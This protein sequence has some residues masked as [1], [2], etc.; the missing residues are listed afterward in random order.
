[1][2]AHW[3][4]SPR[5]HGPPSD[6]PVRPQE[7]SR[8]PL[9]RRL[10]LAREQQSPLAL[11][12]VFRGLNT[13]T[14]PCV[15]MGADCVWVLLLSALTCWMCTEWPVHLLTGLLACPAVFARCWCASHHAGSFRQSHGLMCCVLSWCCC[16]ASPHAQPTCHQ[17]M[18][19]SGCGTKWWTW[20][21]EPCRM[22][23]KVQTSQAVLVTT[24]SG[25]AAV[26][27][28]VGLR[29]GPGYYTQ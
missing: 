11:P 8:Q 17:W 1:M 24:K 19:R 23:T 14:C 3:A 15:T 20:Q 25:A 26:L 10:L 22:H 7:L 4:A 12:A 13:C 29:V 21:S 5:L 2:Y 27:G 6:A 28:L 16:A 18:Q 9:T